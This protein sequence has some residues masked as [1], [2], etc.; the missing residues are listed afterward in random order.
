MPNRALLEHLIVHIFIR[1]NSRYFPPIKM[2]KVPTGLQLLFSNV[3]HQLKLTIAP[4]HYVWITSA[5]CVALD[6]S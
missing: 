1:I 5:H 4:R 2:R 6:L 3:R